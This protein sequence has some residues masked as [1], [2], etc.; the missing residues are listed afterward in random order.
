M[1]MLPW[2]EP[3]TNIRI[4]YYVSKTPFVEFFR[5]TFSRDELSSLTPRRG[6]EAGIINLSRSYEDGTH[7][8]AWFKHSKNA[9]CYFDSMGNISA[10]PELIAYLSPCDIYYNVEREQEPDTVICGQLCLCFIFKEYLSTI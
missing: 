3:L 10:P 8:T 5:G 2:N 1:K 9:A 6:I 4:N 7:W